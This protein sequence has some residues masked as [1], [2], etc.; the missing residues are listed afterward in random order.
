MTYFLFLPLLS[1][2]AFTATAPAVAN[3]ADAPATM[4][5]SLHSVVE[6]HEV[7]V[8]AS[9][10]DNGPL[11]QQP[12]SVTLIGS[13]QMNDHHIVSLKGA[14][15]LVP[16]VFMPD[17]GSRLTS[18]I[19][20]RGIGSR[21][22][23]PAVGLYV[24]NIPY[25]DKSAFDFNFYDIER[26]DVL[27]GPQGTLY[28]R[29]TMGGLMRVY[30]R[31]PFEH[32][33]TDLRLGFATGDSHRN[34]S[35]SH[36]HRLGQHVAFTAGGYYEGGDG[37][38]SNDQTGQKADAMQAGG[39]R[40]RLLFDDNRHWLLDFNV[41]YDYTDEDAYPY[42]YTGSLTGGVE[43][44]PEL[45]G[46]I[47]NNRE[48]TY[49]R[50]LLNAGLN[51]QFVADTWR[52]NAVTGYQYLRDRM[53]M[54][55]D[56]LAP[57]IYTLEQK[58]RIGTFTQ[59][60]TFKNTND[61]RWHWLTGINFMYQ[62]LHTEG[63][64]NFYDDGLR[65]LEGNINGYMPDVSQIPSLNRMGFTSM[66]VNFRDDALNMGGIFETPALNAAVFHQSTF[67]LTSRL[68][69]T[70]GVRLDYE[71]LKM[72]YQAA[73]LVNYGFKLANP[74]AAMMQVDLQ[75]LTSTL[76][77]GGVI[78]RDYLKVLPKATLNYNFGSVGNLYLSVA[79]G[80][81]SGGYNVQMFSDLLQGKMQ[82]AMMLGIQ[83]GVAAYLEQFTAMGMPPSVIGSISQT[84]ADNMPVGEDPTVE[85]VFYRPEYSW[86]YEV[87]THLNLADYR[88]LL[89]AAA[90]LIETRDQQIARFAPSG[91][92]R[93]M[94]NAGR[95]RSYGAE[96]SARFRP[97][98]H[99]TFT[100]N[101][102]FTHATFTD[103]DA[104]GNQDYTGNYVPFVPEQTF[105]LDAAYSHHFEHS[106]VHTLSVGTNLNGTGRLYWT[107]SNSASQP[108]YATLGA[109]MAL[110]TDHLTCTLWGKNL[111]D[112][113]YQSFYFESASRGF[114]QHG[115]PL[116]VG[117]DLT[118]HF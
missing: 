38:F 40:F 73:S 24:D 37:F 85:Q 50:S 52:M 56:F 97:D 87:G 42:F 13:G 14:S 99:W 62:T 71:N 76:F 65:W 82:N 57:D 81:R 7:N 117:V 114:E 100:G 98:S 18:A 31:S 102:G 10:K 86:N 79:K 11:R 49:R 46:H 36:S 22:N 1:A 21:L 116:Q 3:S 112:R 2:A 93:M 105:G 54:D 96:L 104:G 29:N 30:T 94:V 77:Y 5:D 61:S 35:L 72:D 51:V 8:V 34:V 110:T 47:S 32:Q 58:Q 106:F 28:G 80:Q 101:Y 63:P 111:T 91:F 66:S 69:F 107:E 16:N 39:G 103:Y 109:R 64:V 59:E 27:R 19:Y 68:S 60:V 44:Y 95:S 53:F 15:A 25:V 108:F 9:F 55:Q 113:H 43:P 33:G 6:L 70:L 75:D 83:E 17:Y 84:M 41:N 4:G 45:V 115:K 90:F 67:D 74:R 48:S 12:A 26:V 88:L 118:V 20:I 89:D 92:G 78:E 23:T